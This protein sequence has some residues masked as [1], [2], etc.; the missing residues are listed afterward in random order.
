MLLIIAAVPRETTSQSSDW[1]DRSAVN[2]YV[3]NLLNW[4]KTLADEHTAAPIQEN[5][6]TLYSAFGNSFEVLVMK[7]LPNDTTYTSFLF[8]PIAGS[9]PDVIIDNTDTSLGALQIAP[10]DGNILIAHQI[11]IGNS[12]EEFH[13]VWTTLTSKVLTDGQYNSKIAA[14][15]LYAADNA[16]IPSPPPPPWYQP[17]V[18]LG[19]AVLNSLWFQ[20]VVAVV[21]VYEFVNLVLKWWKHLGI[22]GHLRRLSSKKRP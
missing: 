1:I 12:S 10:A 21:V 2:A 6:D 19:W 14:E 16:S 5:P 13:I 7:G 4:Y 22:V 11:V 15:R 9:N 18:N 20:L 17:V 8:T 3:V